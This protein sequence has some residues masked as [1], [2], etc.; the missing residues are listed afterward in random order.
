MSIEFVQDVWRWAHEA[1]ISDRVAYGR[2]RSM[3][4]VRL[5]DQV[6]S[7]SRALMA[8]NMGLVFIAQRR[9]GEGWTYEATRISRPTAV[10]L[11]LLGKYA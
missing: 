11:K 1:E 8:S 3:N 9:N 6:Y 4:E 2:R 10:K 7:M 5:P